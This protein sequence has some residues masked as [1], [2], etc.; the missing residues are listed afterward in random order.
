MGMSIANN[1]S[2]AALD[3]ITDM[4]F[5]I[6]RKKERELTESYV[7]DLTIDAKRFDLPIDIL[8]GGN[9][10]KVLLAKWLATN[11]KVMLLDDPT[12]GIDVGA[13]HDIYLLLSELS[14]MGISIIMSSSE[15]PELLTICDRIIVLR[16]GRL[17]KI[18]SQNEATQEKIMDAAAPLAVA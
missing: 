4:D 15:L 13:K 14:K 3:K 2:L 8:S 17:S 10:Q 6:S 11:P 18:F 12:R 1:L 7:E 9:Q 5:Y 16:E